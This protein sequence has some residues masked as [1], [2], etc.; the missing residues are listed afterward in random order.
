M[1]V[2]TILYVESVERSV[3]FYRALLGI[4]PLELHACVFAS[5]P[6]SEGA[7]LGLWEASDVEPRP[8]GT[9]ARTELCFGVPDR[10]ALEAR[11]AAWAGAGATVVQELSVMSFGD[12]FTVTDPDGHRLRVM[13][14]RQG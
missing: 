8:S 7:C 2:F 9:G 5:F 6:L 12:T 14:P 3:A 10:A 11:C 4:D 13:V 1:P